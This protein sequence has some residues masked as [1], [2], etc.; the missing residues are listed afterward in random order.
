MSED[1]EVGRLRG[2]LTVVIGPMREYLVETFPDLDE[3]RM[4]AIV[5]DAFTRILQRCTMESTMASKPRKP[6][7]TDGEN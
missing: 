3:E 6:R 1:E 4:K 7:R 2:L 5:T